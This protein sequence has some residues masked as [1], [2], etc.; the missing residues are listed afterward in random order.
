MTFSSPSPFCLQKTFSRRPHSKHRPWW[1]LKWAWIFSRPGLGS[2]SLWCSSKTSKHRRKLW[3]KHRFRR[4]Y[5]RKP[6][7]KH[8]HKLKCKC[9]KWI[10][11]DSSWCQTQLQRRKMLLTNKCL[12]NSS[13]ITL[14]KQALLRSR[15]RWASQVSIAAW[16]AQWDLT[17]TP[18]IKCTK[19][20]PTHRCSNSLPR[21]N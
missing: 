3:L 5:R 17:W 4:R 10:W 11:V 14:D 21:T 6:R 2:V 13:V 12:T 18:L 19:C 15:T 7:C 8:K 16:E 9:H 1:T 20:H